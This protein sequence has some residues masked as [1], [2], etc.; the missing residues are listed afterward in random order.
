MNWRIFSNWRMPRINWDL[1]NIIGLFM[2]AILPVFGF[3]LS[4]IYDSLAIYWLSIL[5]A[6]VVII[7]AS[8]FIT[9]IADALGFYLGKLIK[10]NNY[11]WYTMV[12]L[13]IIFTISAYVAGFGEPVVNKEIIRP[14]GQLIEETSRP[15]S[16]EISMRWN[17]ATPAMATSV[18]PV[19]SS[20]T[21]QVSKQKS[22]HSWYHIKFAILCWIVTFIYMFFA[23]SDEATEAWSEAIKKVEGMVIDQSRG[24]QTVTITLADQTPTPATKTPD[25]KS[26]DAIETFFQRH[27]GRLLSLEVIGEFI[28]NFLKTVFKK[29]FRF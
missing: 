2:G 19:A 8:M 20:Q 23:F 5:M 28:A 16:E 26:T 21:K 27:L 11:R 17:G 22:Y 15:W 24:M 9:Y 18:N 12:G 7:I 1:A 25:S 10:D 29:L 14:G 6:I 4:L 13:S 3:V